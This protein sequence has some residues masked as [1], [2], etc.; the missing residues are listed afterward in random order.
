MEIQREEEE[1]DAP[2]QISIEKVPTDDNDLIKNVLEEVYKVPVGPPQV[3]EVDFEGAE[4]FEEEEENTTPFL[5]ITPTVKATEESETETEVLPTVK[6]VEE[7]EVMEHVEQ[8][9]T[10]E[11]KEVETTQP[12]FLDE[13]AGTTFEEPEPTAEFGQESNDDE[14]NFIEDEL[15][16]L[17]LSTESYDEVT[18]FR[19][20][21]GFF[22]SL[23]NFIS[24][25]LNKDSSTEVAT[26]IETTQQYQYDTTTITTTTISTTTTTTTKPEEPDMGIVDHEVTRTTP[27]VVPTVAE[28]VETIATAETTVAEVFTVPPTEEI[29]V[30]TIR[31]PL[32]LHRPKSTYHAP[33]ARDDYLHLESVKKTTTI[34]DENVTETPETTEKVD[35]EEDDRGVSK[36]V[37]GAIRREEYFKNWVQ[38]K[39]RK[40]EDGYKFNLN[41]IPSTTTT[42][43]ES[44]VA[45]E[46]VTSSDNNIPFAPTVLPKLNN[47]ERRQKKI[48]F[49]EKLKNTARNSLFK[50]DPEK[51]ATTTTSTTTTT[52]TTTKK[53]RP[54]YPRGS[55]VNLF[56]KWAGGTLSQAEFEKTVLGVSTAT[57][58][59]V[60]SRIC[61]RGHC[62]NADD[63]AAASQSFNKK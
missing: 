24:S 29:E 20:K 32:R 10:T 21:G 49:L 11:V 17:E 48:S 3:N 16:D 35:D 39:Y 57:E 5:F 38:R 50:K 53:P 56:K 8:L 28:T 55:K 61:V 37:L 31:F 26:T 13:N 63:Q 14:D 22:N 52:T 47:Y 40:P 59:T 46:A 51:E 15:N 54:A 6:H 58:V 30:T 25:F 41:E 42:T 27:E 36:D 18:T 44:V 45:S 4:F 43:E 60:Q 2:I 9:T 62:Y 7:A 23:S 34:L 1:K 12:P 19:P 33:T